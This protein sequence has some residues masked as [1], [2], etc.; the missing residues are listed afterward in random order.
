MLCF[1]D[2][3]LFRFHSCCRVSQPPPHTHTF[4]LFIHL[5]LDTSPSVF[6]TVNWAMRN[7]KVQMCIRD[8]PPNSCEWRGEFFIC[9]WFQFIDQSKARNNWNVRNKESQ[10]W[11]F[12]LTTVLLRHISVESLTSPFSRQENWRRNVPFTWLALTSDVFFSTHV[13]E[14]TLGLN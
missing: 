4:Y 1:C 2:C 14:L 5:L 7:T 13:Q 3:P 12:L 9:W 11:T 6:P 8:L 10:V